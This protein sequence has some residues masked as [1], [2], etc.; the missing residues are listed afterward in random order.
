MDEYVLEMIENGKRMDGRKFEEFRKIEI[1]PNVIKNAEG[2]ALVKFG[3]TQVIAG[4]KLELG[5]PFEDTPNEGVLVV[6]AEFT[7]L[8]SPDFE[9]GPPGEDAIELARIVDRGI[10]SSKCIKMDELCIEAG[11]KVWCVYVDIHIINHKGNLLD[12]SALASLVALLNTKIPKVEGEKILRGEWE[13]SL[14][15]QFKPINVS[16][17]K[18]KDKFFVDPL[19]EEE[20]V[21]EAR[22]SVCVREDG[23]I[24]ALQKQ[25]S[26]TLE[27]NEIEKMIKIAVE[28]SKEIRGLIG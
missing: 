17:C 18:I 12:A 2:S 8:A 10:R 22:L 16:V 20:E 5:E 9:S 27:P 4:V 24:C 19:L 14:P 7:P 1:E 11:K 25:G 21:V 28:K 3:E 23:K 6:N 15:A 13:K 26:G